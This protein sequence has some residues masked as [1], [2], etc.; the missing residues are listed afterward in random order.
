MKTIQVPDLNQVSVESKTILEQ[1]SK[2][3][4]KIPNLYATI[5][6]SAPALKG[7]LE[8]E[9][10]L[11]HDA[12]FTAKERE[13]INLIVSQVNQCDYCLAAHTSLAQLRGFSQA[14]TIAIR[15][16][17]Y[18]EPRLNAIIQLAQSLT[19]QKGNAEPALLEAFFEAGF[20]EKALIELIGLITVRSFA[21][22][23][24]AATNVPIDFPAA[25]P[26]R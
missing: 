12:S 4:G 25:E 16:A 14:D 3:M 7:M 21:N 26:L 5:G 2:R 18:S 20:N 19:A 10:S 23:V 6:Y 15:R 24:Y 22:Y 13:A 1:V 8:F 17:A 11:A 9:A